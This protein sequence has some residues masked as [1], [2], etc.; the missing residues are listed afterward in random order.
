NIGC[1]PSKALLHSSE[2]VHEAHG[3]FAKMGI[4]AKDVS[5][6]PTVDR[7]AEYISRAFHVAENGRP[8]PVVVGLPEDVLSATTSDAD[9]KASVRTLQPV[10][11]ETLGLVEAAL[12]KAERPLILVGGARWSESARVALEAVAERLAIPIAASFRSQDLIDND[13]THYVGHVGIGIDPALAKRVREADV[14][15]TLGARLGEMTTAGYA[16]L[17]VPHPAPLLIHVHPD[18]AELGRVYRAEIPVA[19]DPVRFV[20]RWEEIT[21]ASPASEP[22]EPRRRAI[23]GARADF[24]RFTTP[25]P[26]PTPP[27]VQLDQIVTLMSESLAPDAIITNGAGNYTAW[28]HRFHRYRRFRTQLAPTAGAMGFGVP[29]A[30]AA[31]LVHPEREVIAFA[32]DGCFLMNGQELA[33][34]H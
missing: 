34:A 8:G 21:R 4:I 24:E 19:A 15:L 18:P 1:I 20:Q 32:G 6:V 11:D 22:S 9:P 27:A 13:H 7:L 23:Q 26:P 25:T 28:V 30:V 12:A 2:L 10:D 14:L 33:T 5:V 31:K 17:D 16:H 29:A 3:N